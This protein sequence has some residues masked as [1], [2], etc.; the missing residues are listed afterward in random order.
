[1]SLD[2]GWIG[3]GVLMHECILTRERILMRIYGPTD[4]GCTYD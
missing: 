4:T 2:I 3:D 1:M